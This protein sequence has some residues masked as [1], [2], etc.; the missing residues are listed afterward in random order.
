MTVTLE[1]AALQL[2][3]LVKEAAQGE[4]IVIVNGEMPL[5]KF[6]AAE[7]NRQPRQ[8]GSARHGVDGLPF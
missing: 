5:A 7:P 2:E 4:E 8:P 1:E 3:S 6:V